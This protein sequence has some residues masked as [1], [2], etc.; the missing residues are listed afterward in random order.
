[1]QVSF[2]TGGLA[3]TVSSGFFLLGSREEK[4]TLKPKYEQVYAAASQMYETPH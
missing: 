1:M 4:D 3:V 2:S